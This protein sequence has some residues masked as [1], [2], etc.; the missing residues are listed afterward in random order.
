MQTISQNSD[1]VK[2]NRINTIWQLFGYG[3]Q[4]KKELRIMKLHKLFSATSKLFPR[5]LAS[6]LSIF[7]LSHTGAKTGKI[8]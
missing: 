3:K 8:Y 1:V 4:V 5:N 6:F 2:G 7:F